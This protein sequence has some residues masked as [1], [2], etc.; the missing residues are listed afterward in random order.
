M[1]RPSFMPGSNGHIVDEYEQLQTGAAATCNAYLIGFEVSVTYNYNQGI[2]GGTFTYHWNLYNDSTLI[3]NP[4]T[5]ADPSPRWAPSAAGEYTFNSTGAA[6]GVTL[7]LS[8]QDYSP[9]P[10]WGAQFVITAV[11]GRALATPMAT[12]IERLATPAC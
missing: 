2:Q 9:S 8:A 11:D 3:A 4:T 12:P 10:L 6:F 7:Y 1:F 5:L